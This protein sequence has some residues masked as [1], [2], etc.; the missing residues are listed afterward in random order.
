MR[1]ILVMQFFMKSK[2]RS[3]LHLLFTLTV[4]YCS[5]EIL[6]TSNQN[7]INE[8]ECKHITKNMTEI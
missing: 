7:V 4:L 8:K 6:S 5:V 3:N 2:L 1:N